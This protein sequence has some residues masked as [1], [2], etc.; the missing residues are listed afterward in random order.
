[1][2][3]MNIAPS[4]EP[5]AIRLISRLNDTRDQSQLTLKLSLLHEARNKC[6]NF[7]EKQKQQQQRK[8]AHLR[9]DFGF[10]EFHEKIAT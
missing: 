1:M 4:F 8:I 5:A 9:C 6:D 7:Q 10:G 2:F 3:H